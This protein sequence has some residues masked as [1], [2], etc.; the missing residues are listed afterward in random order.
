M[1][2][3]SHT[4]S[5]LSDH[6]FRSEYGNIVSSISRLLGPGNLELAEDVAQETFYDAVRQW[7]FGLPDS[8]KS[9]LYRVSKNKTIDLI[10][11]NKHEIA[12]PEHLEPLLTSSWSVDNTIEN[13]F[14]P[15]MIEDSKLRMMFAACHPELKPDAQIAFIL[16]SLCGFSVREIANAFLTNEENIQKKL[17]RSRVKFKKSSSFFRQNLPADAIADRTPIIHKC[18]YLLFNEGY[19]ST[20]DGTAIRKDLCLEALS[21]CKV[22][23]AHGDGKEKDTSALLALMCFHSARFEARIGTEGEMIMLQD[24]DRSSWN[25]ELIDLGHGFLDIATECGHISTYV[26][27]AGIS[28]YYCHATS[29]ECTDWNAILSLYQQL[30]E[31]N[32]SPVILLNKAVVLSNAQS[33]QAAIT[34]LEGQANI[35]Q[36]HLFHSIMSYLHQLQGNMPVSISHLEKAI[37]QASTERE[38]LFLQNRLVKLI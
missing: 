26:L 32:P 36:N 17:Y 3:P 22:L 13:A 34:L 8:P 23:S 21:L 31:I 20:Q 33:P 12:L 16:K 25:Q 27:E 7:P 15:Q 9:W 35:H 19:Y 24:Q 14:E 29:Y 11:K 2:T 5:Q 28:G 38:K 1:A 10:R 6:L 30:W 4:A 37:A 18:L